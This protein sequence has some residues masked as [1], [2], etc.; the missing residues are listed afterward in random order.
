M[1]ITAL[2]EQLGPTVDMVWM[3]KL[4]KTT[5]A[6]VGVASLA[7]MT[8][9]A[10]RMGLNTGLRA[11]IARAVGSKDLAEANRVTQQGLVISTLFAVVM[12]MIGG[13]F[14]NS[15]LSVLGVSP[16]VV[17]QGAAYMRIQLVG[18][19]FM[20]LAMLANGVMQAS[21]DTLTPMKLVIATRLFHIVL[22]PFLIFGWWI[23]PRMEASGAAV[24]TIIAQALIGAGI[25]LWILFSGRSRLKP[26]MKGFRFD[27]TTMWRLLKVGLPASFTGMERNFAN[28]VLVKFI[29]P[30]GTVAV[31]AHTLLQRV[32]PFLQMPAQ[33]F[34]QAAGVLAG[35]N[36]GAHLPH[37]AE[38]TGWTAAFVFTGAMVVASL[39]VLS[40]PGPIIRIFN[41]DSDL[42]K[43]AT[44][45]L[46][47]EIVNYMVFGF[48][49]V[50]MN[51]LNSVGDTWIPMW[52]N[53]ISMWVIC[54][55]LS[56]VLSTQTDLGV[57]GVRWAMAIAIVM[58]AVTYIVYWKAG[59]WKHKKI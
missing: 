33:G 42:V 32:D 54:V 39:L 5:M 38:K 48:V 36:L 14:S 57:Y 47:I 37:R 13:F 15:I 29:S 52:T 55:P 40:I 17:S 46:R 45:F 25:G 58:R 9:N 49:M 28:L 50:L 30:F 1:T 12:A 16:E 26:T 56:Y 19:I 43:L 10:A 53:L 35:Q 59:R 8:V 31:A 11:M 51:C 22:C 44:V 34:G 6:G 4:G 7:V 20:S 23:F 18:S 24:T 2:V 41:S 27:G 3:G 21:G